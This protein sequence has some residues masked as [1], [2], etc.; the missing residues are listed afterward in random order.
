M[1]NAPDI[2][3]EL[4]LRKFPDGARMDNLD[5]FL[6]DVDL[7]IDT[8]DFFALEMRRALFAA[9]AEKGI[10]AITVAPIGMGAALLA[11][12]PGKMTFEEYIQMEGQS[13]NEQLLR[14]VLGLSPA[15]LQG[16]SLVDNTRFNLSARKAPSMP[17]GCE[18]CAGVAGTTALKILLNRG[19]VIAAP[20]GLHFD[21]YRNK[22]KQT[23]RPWGNRNPLQRLGLKIARKRLSGSLNRSGVEPAAETAPASPLDRVLDQA[24]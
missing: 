18:L 19:K 7:Y 10:P 23:W 4:E 3:P 24:R 13:E 8:I 20:R 6:Q 5:A 17:M 21:A 22:L 15:M 1:P 12:M 9:C 14:F 2:N 16:P 11:F